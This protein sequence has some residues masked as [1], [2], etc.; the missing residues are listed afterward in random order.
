MLFDQMIEAKARCVAEHGVPEQFTLSSPDFLTFIGTPHE[1]R[2]ANHAAT[3]WQ[4]DQ[5]SV[6]EAPD[7]ASA[8]HYF[9]ASDVATR[10][11]TL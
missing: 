8:L 6:T 5:L 3:I 9:S 11:M 2:T 1:L 7:D 4:F 10:T